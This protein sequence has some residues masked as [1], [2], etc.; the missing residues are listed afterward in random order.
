MRRVTKDPMNAEKLESIYQN[1]SEY[2][3]T[4]RKVKQKGIE[5]FVGSGFLTWL[6]NV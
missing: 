5:I 1:N 3:L 6:R 4:A 2:W